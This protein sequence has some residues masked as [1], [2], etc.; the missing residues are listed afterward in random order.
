MGNPNDPTVNP[1]TDPNRSPLPIGGVQPD[2]APKVAAVPP[3]VAPQGAPVQPQATQGYQQA[4]QGQT[5]RRSSTLI[6]NPKPVDEKPVERTPE[7]PQSTLEEMA[8]GQAALKRNAPTAAAL[9]AAR[10]KA[11]AD[12]ADKNKA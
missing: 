12:K 3:Q 4:A 10:A 2:A 8:A 11:E 5:I 9:E 6:T 1:N 7:V